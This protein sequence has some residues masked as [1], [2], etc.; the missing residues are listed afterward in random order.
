[1]HIST[2]SLSCWFPEFIVGKFCRVLQTIRKPK[3]GDHPGKKSSHHFVLV[4]QKTKVLVCCRDCHPQW[5]VLQSF[6]P[7]HPLEGPWYNSN[8]PQRRFQRIGGESF[9]KQNNMVNLLD[10]RGKRRVNE[11]NSCLMERFGRF[12]KWNEILQ[13]PVWKLTVCVCMYIYIYHTY[14]LFP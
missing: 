3:A 10:L 14:G 6:D 7:P 1:M 4:Q 8:Q 5:E 9:W 12:K 2:P 11:E 13:L